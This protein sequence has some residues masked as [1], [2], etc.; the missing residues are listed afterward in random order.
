MSQQQPRR[1]QGD[2]DPIKYGDLFPV[3]GKLASK[4]IAPQDAAVTQSAE[5]QA[6]GKTLKGEP[7]SVMQSA[8]DQNERR[9]LIDHNYMTD[10]VRDE[11]V[12]VVD[13][14]YPGRRT[15]T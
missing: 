10:I 9:G 11:G 13:E 2:Q 7:A 12:E 14:E 3:S 4:P 15:I 8:A 6:I 5:T 1:P